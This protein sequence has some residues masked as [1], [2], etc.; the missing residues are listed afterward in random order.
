VPSDNN[1]IKYLKEG[2]AERASIHGPTRLTGTT[3]GSSYVSFGGNKKRN[4]Q[5]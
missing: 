1:A 2:Q 3:G 5:Y 4:N